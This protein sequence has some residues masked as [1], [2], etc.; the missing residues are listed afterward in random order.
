M[1]A[2]A[3]RRLDALI[4]VQDVASNVLLLLKS[5]TMSFKA[6]WLF[7]SSASNYWFV[8]PFFPLSAITTS[9]LRVQSNG[10]FRDGA[11]IERETLL[12]CIRRGTGTEAGARDHGA[13]WAIHSKKF[14]II[15]DQIHLW[16]WTG[17]IKSAGFEQN[18]AN[19]AAKLQGITAQFRR[20]T[21][22]TRWEPRAQQFWTVDHDCDMIL[23]KCRTLTTTLIFIAPN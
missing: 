13:G 11:A 4:L 5:G 15:L 9:R 20:L 14:R 8:F 16:G 17:V 1:H 10:R 3:P 18:V 23:V 2:A 22:R 12:R 21:P 19:I 6:S 7:N